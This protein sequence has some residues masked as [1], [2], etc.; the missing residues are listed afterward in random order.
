[1]QTWQHI[2]VIVISKYQI[3]LGTI[4]FFNIWKLKTSKKKVSY[5]QFITRKKFAKSTILLFK[6][7]IQNLT[8]YVKQNLPS[9]TNNFDN[10]LVALLFFRFLYKCVGKN[11]SQKIFN[12]DSKYFTPVTYVTLIVNNYI[13]TRD[14]HWKLYSFISTILRW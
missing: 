7:S 9:E 12:I 1:M 5:P 13:I 14:N 11:A 2:V 6:I 3:L 8:C 4:F 10:Q